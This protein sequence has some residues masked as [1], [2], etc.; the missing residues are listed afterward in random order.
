MNLKFYLGF[1]QLP[2][3]S[4]YK[5][6]FCKST[7]VFFFIWFCLLKCKVF[8]SLKKSPVLAETKSGHEKWT[9]DF[10]NMHVEMCS[11]PS[12]GS[13]AAVQVK[14]WDVSRNPAVKLLTLV[15]W[16]NGAPS[17]ISITSKITQ[18]TL[19]GGQLREKPHCCPGVVI[20][21]NYLELPGINCT[22]DICTNT[23]FYLHSCKFHWFVDD[24]SDQTLVIVVV[25]SR[26]VYY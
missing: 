2:S 14:V 8:D 10:Q 7:Y 22:A 17:G 16:L 9:T 26:G 20:A 5:R 18:R 15:R 11:S 21:W 3:T 12:V 25:Q 4:F 1:S 24:H 13:R 6:Y 19:G 23:H